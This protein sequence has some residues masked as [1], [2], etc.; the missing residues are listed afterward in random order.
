MMFECLIMGDSIAVGIGQAKPECATIARVGITSKK[1]NKDFSNHLT[2]KKSYKVVVI[3]LSTNDMWNQT[4]ESLYDIR[5]KV[6]SNMVVWVL[7]SQTLKPK[8]R[9]IVKAMAEEFGDKVLDITNKVGPDGI[10]P[11]NLDSYRKIAKEISW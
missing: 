7:P 3:S 6:Q 4:T 2:F 11:P 5:S 10:H 8:Q 9:A 1:W